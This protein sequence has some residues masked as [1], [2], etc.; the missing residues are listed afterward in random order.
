MGSSVKK[1]FLIGGHCAAASNGYFEARINA[2][3]TLEKWLLRQFIGPQLDLELRPV[4]MRSGVDDDPVLFFSQSETGVDGF[5]ALV[6]DDDEFPLELSEAVNPGDTLRVYWVN[7]DVGN[8]YDFWSI[9]VVD[10]MAGIH[11]AGGGR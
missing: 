9:A 11:R 3:G 2:P 4:I 7:K 6:G 10:F 5:K 8:A 1:S